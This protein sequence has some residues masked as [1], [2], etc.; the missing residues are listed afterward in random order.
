MTDVRPKDST[1][2]RRAYWT[3]RVAIGS[4]YTPPL[5]VMSADAERIQDAMM[6][7]RRREDKRV[8][9][10]GAMHHRFGR[11]RTMAR[12]LRKL[13]RNLLRWLCS[14]NA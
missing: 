9:M 3:G 10:G 11:R 5:P 1:F 4:A 7:W 13:M 6:A 8:K 12:R 2:G 14:P